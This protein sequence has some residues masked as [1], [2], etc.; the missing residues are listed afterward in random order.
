MFTRVASPNCAS[1]NVMPI[2]WRAISTAPTSRSVTPPLRTTLDPGAQDSAPVAERFDPGTSTFSALDLDVRQRTEHAAQLDAQGRLWL[3]GGCAGDCPIEIYD[4]AN[5]S[6]KPLASENVEGPAGVTALLDGR[7]LLAAQ[8]TL[9]LVDPSAETV[10]PAGVSLTSS[11]AQ[12]L[13]LP[14]GRVLAV[15]GGQLLLLRVSGQGMVVVDTLATTADASGN[16]GAALMVDGGVFISSC[17]EAIPFEVTSCAFYESLP[18]DSVQPVSLPFDS[19]WPPR[20]DTPA[21]ALALGEP[22][23]LTGDNL[24][25]LLEPTN[26]PGIGGSNHPVAV[27]MPFGGI[28]ALSGLRHWNDTSAEYTPTPLQAGPGYLFASVAGQLGGAPVTILQAADGTSCSSNNECQSGICLDGFCCEQACAAC[29]ACSAELKGGG[30]DGTCG[31]ALADTDPHDDCT[32]DDVATCDANGMCDGAGQCA[33][34]ADGT[35]CGEGQFCVNHQCSE[36]CMSD[37]DCPEGLICL[38]QSCVD[39][40]FSN[41]DCEAGMVCGSEGTCIA[42]LEPAGPLGC[43]PCAIGRDRD[44]AAAAWWLLGAALFAARRRRNKAA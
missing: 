24:L 44:R 26:G 17:L 12:L 3:F 16:A 30:A 21:A 27:F 15:D 14:S 4:Q 18:P 29:E 23:A 42:P 35:E 41:L 43:A 19:A 39:Q 40:C 10:V 5:G 36:G 1:V 2:A 9:R 11:T 8:S 32:P 31:P 25:G 28:P 22:Y 34:Y 20:L 37:D 38:D 33:L 6:V 7:M 13:L